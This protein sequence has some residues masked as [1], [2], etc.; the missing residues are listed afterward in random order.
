MFGHRAEIESSHAAMQVWCSWLDADVCEGALSRYL[1]FKNPQQLIIGPFSHDTDFND[2]PF[3]TPAQHS[4]SEPT[5]EQQNRMM[6]DFFSTASFVLTFQ[7]RSSPASTITHWVRASGTIQ[8]Y[9]RRRD[10]SAPANSIS[11]WITLS[12][13]HR[14]RPPL[15]TTLTQSTSQR[16]LARIIA[17]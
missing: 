17:G 3:L 6:A 8:R 1:T 14:P 9:G 13:Q 16:P 5:V 4:P 7:L 2:D 12:A 11:R 10:S 15:P